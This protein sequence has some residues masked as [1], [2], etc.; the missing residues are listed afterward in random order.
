MVFSFVLGNP[1]GNLKLNLESVTQNTSHFDGSS[2]YDINSY[3]HRFLSG[4]DGSV[5]NSYPI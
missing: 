1:N 5:N 3:Y 4:M 2:I